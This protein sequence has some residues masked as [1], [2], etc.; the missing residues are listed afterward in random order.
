MGYPRR[1]LSE[2]E[3][4]EL[5]AHPHWKALVVPV[6]VLL[7][8][9]GATCFLAALLSEFSGR[10]WAWLAMGV[11][12]LLIVLRWT[13]WPWL[14]WINTQYVLSNRRLIVRRGVIARDGRDIPLSRIND[15]SFSHGSLLERLLSCGTLVVESAGERGQL[16][17][18]NLPRVEE[19]QRELY[20]LVEADMARRGHL[21]D[22]D[23]RSDGA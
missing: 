8:V 23:R 16:V 14:Q 6:A 18:A 13:F 5:E 7:L 22:D 20:R 11:L 2:G 21:M 12:A 3:M 10:R 9:V 4:V 17:L 1:L 19:T 15:L